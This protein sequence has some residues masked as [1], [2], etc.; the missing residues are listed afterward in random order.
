M[1]RAGHVAGWFATL[2]LSSAGLA[3]Q[4]AAQADAVDSLVPREWQVEQRHQADF[5]HDGRRDALLLLQ[6]PGGRDIPARM[7]LV[8]FAGPAGDYTLIESNARLIPSDS[9]GQLEDPMAD[10]ELVMRPGGF[11]LSIGMLSTVGSYQ[12][13]TIRYR[14]RFDGRCFRL[15]AHDR[16]HTNRATL[17]TLDVKV[18]L[19]T[20]EVTR[21][22]GNAE[23]DVAPQTT[24]ER[25]RANPRRCLADLGNGWTFDPLAAR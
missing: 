6:R 14:F 17:D 15:V 12:Q 16:L 4:R 24:R 2:L 8:A 25:L 11:D 20:G 13:A 18:S 3:G 9:S 10:G 21:T 7:L 23:S 22:S 19:L 5:N 1:P